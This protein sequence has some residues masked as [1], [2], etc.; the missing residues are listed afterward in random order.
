MK[1]LITGYE[2]GFRAVSLIELLVP[3]FGGL[4]QAKHAVEAMLAGNAI[5]IEVAD[6]DGDVLV[7]EIT[8]TGAI[9]AP[10]S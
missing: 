7:R 2:Y 8:A 4:A 6:A 3:R 10:H 9:C 5:A 1:L